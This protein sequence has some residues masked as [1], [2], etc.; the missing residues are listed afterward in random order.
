M[1]VAA[2]W[3]QGPRD[4]TRPRWGDGQ[5]WADYVAK[6]GRSWSAPLDAPAPVTSVSTWAAPRATTTPPGAPVATGPP[7][8]FQS[9]R[10][11]ATGLLVL[12]VVGAVLSVILAIALFSRA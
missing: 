10:G 11:L 7:P 3:Y 12:F 6:D 5:G 9:V 8:R 1:A 4:G 2:G